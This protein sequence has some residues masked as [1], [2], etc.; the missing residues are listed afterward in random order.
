MIVDIMPELSLEE[1]D[2]IKNS[3]L[4]QI[5]TSIKTSVVSEI[6]SLI[7]NM[8]DIDLQNFQSFC[9]KLQTKKDN[10]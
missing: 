7:E 2:E 3:K 9:Q 6:Q 4:I 8:L 1:L 10:P 5:H